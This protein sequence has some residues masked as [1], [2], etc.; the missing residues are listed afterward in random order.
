MCWEPSM[1]GR[2]NR[3]CA[4]SLLC[5]IQNART[6]AV[7]IMIRSYA[8][9]DAKSQP[10]PTLFDNQLATLLEIKKVGTH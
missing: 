3:Q 4:G 10:Q 1:N 6:T 8:A 2:Q 5:E 7:L 9:Q